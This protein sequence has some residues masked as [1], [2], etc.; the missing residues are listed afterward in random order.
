MLEINDKVSA[1]A[2][3]LGIDLI[4]FDDNYFIIKPEEFKSICSESVNHAEIAEHLNENY[5]LLDDFLD[6]SSYDDNLYV[7]DGDSYLILDYEEAEE[8]ERANIKEFAITEIVPQFPENL[9]EYFDTDSWVRD[10]MDLDD[11]GQWISQYDG[12]EHSLIYDDKGYYI[13]RMD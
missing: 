7:Y 1:L 8:R 12:Y 11:R 6:Q 10:S 2:E 3:Y 13:Y 9:Q 4:K 5:P